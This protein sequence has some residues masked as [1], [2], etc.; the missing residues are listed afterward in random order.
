M[1]ITEHVGSLHRLDVA[2]ALYDLF[3]WESFRGLV[4]L[5]FALLA[6]T[7]GPHVYMYAE[8]LYQNADD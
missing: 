7:P 2:D 5:T 6:D 8:F 1:C 3:G 4:G